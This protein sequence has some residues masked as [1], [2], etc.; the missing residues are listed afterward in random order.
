MKLHNVPAD[1]I[2]S[3]WIHLSSGFASWQRLFMI[4]CED[5]GLYFYQAWNP[6]PCLSI[7]LTTFLEIV[8]FE[9]PY[10]SRQ[11][12]DLRLQLKILTPPTKSLISTL[13]QG[14]QVMLPTFVRDAK[15]LTA[16]MPAGKN[17]AHQVQLESLQD[18][19]AQATPGW[20][21]Q[22]TCARA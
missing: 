3:E 12:H 7:N 11:G 15:L 19:V 5:G 18:Q 17:C 22:P 20:Q 10:T 16:I 2:H 4:A 8:D 6:E 1:E 14:F 21:W 9:S 13:F